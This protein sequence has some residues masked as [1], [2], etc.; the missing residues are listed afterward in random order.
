MI[1][2]RKKE[3]RSGKTKDLMEMAEIQLSLGRKVVVLVHNMVALEYLKNH[4]SDILNADHDGKLIVSTSQNLQFLRGHRTDSILVDE[5]SLSSNKRE[6]EQFAN[7][8]N[9]EIYATDDIS[10]NTAIFSNKVI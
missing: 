6:I 3:R 5:W 7:R 4:Y 9:A 10:Y 1:N 2:I 8:C